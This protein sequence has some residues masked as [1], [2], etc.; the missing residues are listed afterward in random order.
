[1]KYLILAAL[2]L[3]AYPASAQDKC[4]WRIKDVVQDQLRGSIVVKAEYKIDG[5]IV[6][7]G[8]TRYDET[9][10]T[11]AHVTRMVKAD[12]EDQCR[13]LLNTEKIANEF[14]KKPGLIKKKRETGYLLKKL[15]KIKGKKGE[16]KK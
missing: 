6:Y 10:G 13:F 8:E 14:Y 16:V 11:P 4:E 3:I 12:L 15:S 2:L 7:N 9:S 1:M 5:Y